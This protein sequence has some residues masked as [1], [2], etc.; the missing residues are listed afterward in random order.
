MKDK[1]LR[2]EIQK[3][4]GWVPIKTLLRFNRLAA[5]T[6]NEDV[7]LAAFKS[8]PSELMEVSE[9]HPVDVRD[10][11]LSKKNVFCRLTRKI[12]PYDVIRTAPYQSPVKTGETSLPL[13]QF[14][15]KDSPRKLRLWMIFSSLCRRLV[16]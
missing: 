12:N 2:A 16:K 5:L 11:H 8:N 10:H 1:F 4:D 15:S 13:D 14:I 9:I 6:K 3:N 7:V